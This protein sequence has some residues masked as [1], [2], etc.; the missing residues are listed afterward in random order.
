MT[1]F[2]LTISQFHKLPNGSTNRDTVPFLL[3]NL[4][5]V[6]LYAFLFTTGLIC[7]ILLLGIV[8]ILLWLFC[9]IIYLPYPNLQ[10]LWHILLFRKIII[11]SQTINC[12]PAV[13]NQPYSM[14]ACSLYSSKENNVSCIMKHKSHLGHSFRC[15]EIWRD[16]EWE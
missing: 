8:S 15:K 10:Y 1:K 13:K 9:I 4:S 3:K 6:L 12:I 5:Q 2:A 14:N 16:K 7:Y 11:I